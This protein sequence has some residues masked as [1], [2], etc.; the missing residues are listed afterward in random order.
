MKLTELRGGEKNVTLRKTQR[1]PGADNLTM[2][3]DSTEEIHLNT[4]SIMEGHDRIRYIRLAHGD[5]LPI[6]SNSDWEWVQE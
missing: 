4:V 3:C 1:T 6:Y 2:R 5:L